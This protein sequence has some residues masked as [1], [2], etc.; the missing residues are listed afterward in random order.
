MPSPIVGLYFEHKQ[1]PSQTCCPH[2]GDA[3]FLH[4]KVYYLYD[5]PRQSGGWGKGEE[6]KNVLQINTV[7]TTNWSHLVAS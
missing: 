6:W 5:N 3:I 1:R 4:Y 2:L 7:S